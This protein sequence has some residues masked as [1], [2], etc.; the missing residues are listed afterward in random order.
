MGRTWPMSVIDLFEYIKHLAKDVYLN[1]YMT[2]TLIVLIVNN[3]LYCEQVQWNLDV[4]N[5]L[6]KNQTD[7]SKRIVAQAKA[8]SYSIF[9]YSFLSTQIAY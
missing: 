9:L 4:K 2:I 6:Y 3:Y 8:F 1:V 5:K 7:F